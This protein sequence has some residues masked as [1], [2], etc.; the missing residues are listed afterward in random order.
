MTAEK[1]VIGGLE[2]EDVEGRKPF[3]RRRARQKGSRCH[4]MTCDSCKAMTMFL[5]CLLL[6]ESCI[7]AAG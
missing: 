6:K 3:A 4:V 5:T 2:F 1:S 7:W